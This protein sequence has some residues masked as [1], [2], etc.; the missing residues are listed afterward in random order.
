MIKYLR[1]LSY[2][3]ACKVIEFV[4][5]ND[6]NDYAN[7]VPGGVV[8]EVSEKNWSTVEQFIQSLEVRYEIS[9]IPPHKVV[10]SIKQTL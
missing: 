5:I 9:N 6:T 2:P 10:E 7:I 4:C 1:L 3:N 8:L